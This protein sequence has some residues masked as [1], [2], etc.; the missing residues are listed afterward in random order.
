MPKTW[1]SGPH[2]SHSLISGRSLTNNGLLHNSGLRPSRVSFP[3][4]YAD[5]VHHTW[6]NYLVWDGASLLLSRDAMHSGILFEPLQYYRARTKNCPWR[7]FLNEN[8]SLALYIHGC[9][10][11]CAPIR[12]PRDVLGNFIYII[13]RQNFVARDVNLKPRKHFKVPPIHYTHTRSNGN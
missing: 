2:I 10:C 7:A 1:R 9:V 6:A 13:L 12:A 4:R 3:R 11:M 5:A 8:F